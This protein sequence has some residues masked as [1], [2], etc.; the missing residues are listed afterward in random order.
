MPLQTCSAGSAPVPAIDL[1]VA[2]STVHVS[3]CSVK[4]E[5]MARFFLFFLAYCWRRNTT[6]RRVGGVHACM[7]P[8]FF[9]GGMLRLI[10]RQYRKFHQ[11]AGWGFASCIASGR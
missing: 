10:L 11:L 5:D 3:R 6:D 2:I 1:T 8:F 9:K 7:A 4:H